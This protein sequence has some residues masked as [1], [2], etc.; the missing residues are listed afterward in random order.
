MFVANDEYYRVT[1]SQSKANSGWRKVAN[2]A[3]GGFGLL[4][5]EKAAA[6]CI[7]ARI[8]PNTRFMC[9]GILY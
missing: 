7:E 9:Q 3:D 8:G 2:S 6:C 1:R 4:G 5:K